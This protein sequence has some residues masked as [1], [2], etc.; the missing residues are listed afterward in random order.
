MKLPLV[1][2]KT[3]MRILLE[4]GYRRI[5]QSG[6]HIQ[7]KNSGGT[8]VTVPLHPGRPIGRGLLHKILRDMELSREE[9]LKQAG[10]G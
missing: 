9:F 1:D 8:I 2:A 6:S 3:L 10:K 5:G 4:N 7:F